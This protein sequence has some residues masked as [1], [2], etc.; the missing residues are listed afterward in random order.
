MTILDIKGLIVVAI[1]GF[2]CK[3][4]VPKNIEPLY[5]L[6]SDKQT[7]IKLEEQD[8]YTYL[9]CSWMA[10]EIDVLRDARV[11]NDMF[12][13]LHYFPEATQGL[14]GIGV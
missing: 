13:D 1:R 9:D 3:K 10:R 2:N 12:N 6:F 8:G 4:K 11:W 14:G 5:I 7:Y